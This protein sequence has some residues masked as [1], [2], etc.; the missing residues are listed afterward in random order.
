MEWTKLL[1][2]KIEVWIVMQ[3]N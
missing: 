2:D 1:A 3:V